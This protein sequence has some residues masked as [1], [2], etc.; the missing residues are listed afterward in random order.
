[1]THE[2]QEQID[3]A[4]ATLENAINHV[5]ITVVPALVAMLSRCLATSQIRLN[6]QAP[7]TPTPEDLLTMPEVAQR[8]KVST[9]RAYELARHG[10]LK[11][12]RMGKSVRVTPAA[13]AEYI[14]HLGA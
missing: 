3:H 1:M 14:T 9:Y 12:V 6:G 13:L 7:T 10:K 11:S 8:L 4:T 5:P 2:A